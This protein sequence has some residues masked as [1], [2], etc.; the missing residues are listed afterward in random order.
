M[1]LPDCFL[2]KTAIAVPMK[3]SI[4]RKSVV[5]LRGTCLRPVFFLSYCRGSQFSLGK[6]AGARRQKGR[7][8]LQQFELN[9]KS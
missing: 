8:P 3:K 7:D 4:K 5:F 1:F 9:P 2:L 6:Q